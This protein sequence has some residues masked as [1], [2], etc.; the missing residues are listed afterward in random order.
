MLALIVDV[1]G[2]QEPTEFKKS[3][4]IQ[5]KNQNRIYEDKKVTLGDNTGAP[6]SAGRHFSIFRKA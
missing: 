5:D 4:Q 3:K 1:D 6:L 2:W